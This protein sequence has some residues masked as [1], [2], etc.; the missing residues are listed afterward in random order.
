M[1]EILLLGNMEVNSS[2]LGVNEISKV[3][4]ILGVHFTFNHPLFCKL[5]FESIE[6][7]LRGLLKGWSW[8]GLTL[9][10]KIQVIKSFVIPKIL[11][12]AV[13]I[14]NR[15]EFVK[16][17]NTLLY[18][19]VWKGKD[20]VKRTAFINPI[21]KGGLKMPNI[22]SMISAQRIICI[23]RYLSTDP[24]SWKIFLDFYPKKV[25]RKFLFHCNF[26][27]NK[28][29]ITLPEFYKEC[30]VA[31]TLL[32]E[33]NPSSSSEITN[34]VIWNNQFICIE[35]KSI[36]NRRLIDLG[37]VRIGDL[38][39]TRRE[40]KSH[41]EPLYS[42]LSP[43]EHFLLFS[44]FNAFPEEWRKILKTNKTSIS[45]ETHNLIQTDFKLRI[46]DRNRRFGASCAIFKVT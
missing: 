43:V 14:S 3:V 23:K 7:S 6:K 38:Y 27:Y 34:Q 1:T 41:K 20:K 25:G 2:E 44:L 8:R 15:K 16:K 18:S 29:P 9:L 42:T 28:L 17:I 35:S 11:Y 32:N 40:F 26:N 4:K 12:R 39:D 21:A 13:L 10:G 19:F 45:S 24:A 31:W 30:T 46:S 37:I 36:Y 22:E 5:N 33:D